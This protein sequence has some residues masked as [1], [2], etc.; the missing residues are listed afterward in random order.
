MCDFVAKIIRRERR[1]TQKIR[2]LNS[3]IQGLSKQLPKNHSNLI[4][5][6]FGFPSRI[7]DEELCIKELKAIHEVLSED[8]LFFT[9]GW[10]ETF[11][12][13]LN[14]MWFNYIPD[15]IVAKDFEDWR[16][17]RSGSIKSPRNCDL[18]W[19]K[20]GIHV[21]LQFSTIQESAHV[22]GYLFGRDAASYIIKN[23]KIEWGMSLGITCNTKSEIANI[24]KKYERNRNTR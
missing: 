23:G 17:K 6:S 15:K 24:I 19:I 9:I 7:S 21:P 13:E 12:D 5:S 1:Y 2:V 18:K 16:Q 11:N 8:G 20:R 4:V 3:T 14:R 10:D 22:M